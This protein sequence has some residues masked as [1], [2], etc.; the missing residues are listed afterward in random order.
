MYVVVAWNKNGDLIICIHPQV[1]V[2]K[3]LQREIYQL[4]TLD[5]ILPELSKA[6][7]C[8]LHHQSKISLLARFPRFFTTPQSQHPCGRYRWLR[9]T[10]GFNV[11]S[12]MY[13]RQRRPIQHL[14]EMTP[15][16]TLQPRSSSVARLSTRSLRQPT[17]D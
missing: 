17:T 3:V 5:D 14:V 10:L 11:S 7:T 15:H 13:L 2:N 8:I 1:V 4:H 9:M 6:Y 16:G 12:E